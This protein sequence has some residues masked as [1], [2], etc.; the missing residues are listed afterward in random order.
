MRQVLMGDV[1]AAARVLLAD[2]PPH[3]PVLLGRMI[4]QAEQ[5]DHYRKRLG[6]NHPDWGNGSL[7]AAAG[8][9]PQAPEPFLSDPD[10]LDCLDM[11]LVRLALRRCRRKPVFSSCRSFQMK[12]VDYLV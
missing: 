5:A 10:Y 9:W 1:I 6:R 2:D 7:M 4:H 12:T 8:V 3:R 11:V